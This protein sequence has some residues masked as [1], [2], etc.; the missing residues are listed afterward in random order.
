MERGYSNEDPLNWFAIYVLDGTGDLHS[1]FA[2]ATSESRQTA[3]ELAYRIAFLASQSE[4]V[5]AFNK[6]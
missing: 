6:W 5:K 2:T 1:K 3:K 4:I